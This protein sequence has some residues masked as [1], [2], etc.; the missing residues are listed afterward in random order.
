MKL[1]A[2]NIQITNR[3]IEK[4]L[5]E[6]DPYPIQELAV[7]CEKAGAQ[8]LDINSGPLLRDPDKKMLFLVEAVQ[9]VSDLPVLL[10]TANPRAIEAGLLANRKKA[11]I[12]GFSME[13]VKL[14]SILPLAKRFEA[15]II[16]YL[17]YPDSHVPSDSSER[18]N[19]AVDLYQECQKR[20][21]DKEQL[22][23]DPVILPMTWQS[24]NLQNIFR[25]PMHAG[26]F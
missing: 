19:I 24:G 8:A 5:A 12:N 7:K 11:V 10:D 20:G 1:I 21:I 3:R 13:P 26:S 23:I 14:E 16:G 25:L 2:D 4:A 22:I 17:I 15:D 6:M 18:L 9:E